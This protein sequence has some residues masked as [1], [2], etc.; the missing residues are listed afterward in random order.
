MYRSEKRDF[1]RAAGNFDTTTG[2]AGERRRLL[3]AMKDCAQLFGEV[4]D[5]RPQAVNRTFLMAQAGPPETEVMR[6]SE[7]TTSSSR[8]RIGTILALPNLW[9][10]RGRFRARLRADL[11]D[12]TDFLHDI[13]I[14]VHEAR[15]EASRFFWEPIILKPIA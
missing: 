14:H 11:K 8:L 13:G 12:N 5:M 7:S 15:A 4:H 3:W 6:A 1:P 2:Y 10:E 9:R